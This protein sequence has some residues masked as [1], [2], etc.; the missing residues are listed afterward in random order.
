L[1]IFRNEEKLTFLLICHSWV[2]SEVMARRPICRD[3][4]TEANTDTEKRER[5]GH[6][7][8]DTDR[9]TQI[10]TVAAIPR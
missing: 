2:P 8:G 10:D 1:W 7:E 4:E 5:Q 9:D 6:R 3:T